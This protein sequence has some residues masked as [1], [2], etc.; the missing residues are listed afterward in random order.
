MEHQASVVWRRT[1]K[2]FT[3]DIYNRADEMRFGD[4]V[5]PAS[6][7]KEFKGDPERVNPE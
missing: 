7:A 2:E 6:A 3:Y 4:V 1:T 5:V